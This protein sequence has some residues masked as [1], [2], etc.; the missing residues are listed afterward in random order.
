MKT[1]NL[2][3]RV[4]RVELKFFIFIICKPVSG[5]HRRFEI[6]I[7]RQKNN[8]T[9]DHKSFAIF[10]LFVNRTQEDP[11]VIEGTGVTNS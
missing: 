9:V 2:V 4:N 11:K 10:I 7:A 6:T 1:A 5:V 8:K 3:E